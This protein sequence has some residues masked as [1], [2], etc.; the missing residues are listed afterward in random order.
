M[1]LHNPEAKGGHNP[2]SHFTLFFFF[3]DPFLLEA[4]ADR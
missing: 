3:K 2:K 1:D 4:K